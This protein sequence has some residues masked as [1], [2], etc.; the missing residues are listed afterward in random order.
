MM[1]SRPSPRL[2]SAAAR[3]SDRARQIRRTIRQDCDA[4]AGLGSADVATGAPLSAESFSRHRSRRSS[5]PAGFRRFDRHRRR[6]RMNKQPATTQ[7]ARLTMF[8]FGVVACASAVAI[9]SAQEVIA[10]PGY[11]KHMRT[12]EM[13]EKLDANGD[14]MVSQEEGEKYFRKLFATLDANHDGVL[15]KTEWAGAASNVEVISLSNGGYARALSSMG[16]MKICDS[17]GDSKV[18]ENE[19]LQAHQKLFNKMASGQTAIDTDHWVAAHFPVT[20]ARH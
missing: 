1:A 9:E 18:T 6:I 12:L 16:M 10:T 7:R 4:I 20:G 15:D 3:A 11:E 14:H 2:T 17:D 19:F 5:T 13:M 8:L